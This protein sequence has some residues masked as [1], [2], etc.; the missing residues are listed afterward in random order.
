MVRPLHRRFYTWC[1]LLTLPLLVSRGRYGRYIA[2]GRK[3]WNADELD[4]LDAA[5][6]ASTLN[7]SR[8]LGRQVC[9][10]P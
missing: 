10:L 7:S 5:A 3:R 4:E 8:L 2:N 1:A 6:P 9:D